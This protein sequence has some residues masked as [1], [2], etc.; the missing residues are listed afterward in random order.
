MNQLHV[1][2]LLLRTGEH[3]DFLCLPMLVLQ[4]L[5]AHL[6]GTERIVVEGKPWLEA[7]LFAG[8][9]LVVRQGLIVRLPFALGPSLVVSRWEETE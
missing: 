6:P 9:I 4:Q 8:D 1:S 2:K 3:P 7:A 5:P